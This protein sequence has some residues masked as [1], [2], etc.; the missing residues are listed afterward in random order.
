MVLK[1]LGALRTFCDELASE[2][3][4]P[5]GGTASAAAGAVAASLLG[6]VC[7][8]TRKSKKAEAHWGELDQLRAALSELQKELLSLAQE[9]AQAYDLVVE[10]FRNRKVKNDEESAKGVET[11]LKYATEVP[12]RTADACLMVLKAADRVAE[13][14]SKNAY[15]DVAVAIY[16][17]KAGLFGALMNVEINLDGNKDEQY[18]A[19]QRH[20]AQARRCDGEIMS[21]RALSKVG[22]RGK[23]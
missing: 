11:A 4:S 17:A 8:I 6:M 22:K 20:D 7:A 1:D 14:G 13:T 9:D 18:V 21:Q 2:Q 5:G 23:A 3:P 10:A 15:S 12:S 19:K 16:L